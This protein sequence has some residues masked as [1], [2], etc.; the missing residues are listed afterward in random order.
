MTAI[1]GAPALR[2]RPR[3]A[4]T[5]ALAGA[6]G[7]LA[8]AWPL[9]IRHG[10]S[11]AH[12]ADAPWLF[13]L[14]LVLVLGVVL[15]EIAEGGMDAKAVALLGVLAAIG[16]ALRPLGAGA[17]GLETVWF[18]FV[19]AGRVLG[20]GF[21]FALGA[22]TLFASALL[23]A[24]VGPWLPFQMFGAAW[25]GFGAGCLPRSVRGRWEIAMLAGYGAL[26]ALAYGVLLDL[27]FWP[28][29]VAGSG[30]PSTL[31]YHPGAPVSDNLGRFVAFHLT[32]SMGFDLPRAGFTALLVALA[33]RPVLLA[34][35]R[36]ARRAAFGATAPR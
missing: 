29:T 31:A 33:A 10:S 13:V 2:L 24:G 4:L 34:L 8:F 9:L 26:A 16:A 25:V 14:L 18:L 3:T 20:R 17:A 11:V 21:G 23:T 5:L 32:T 19:L 27:S 30:A 15:A 1:S 22:L 36:A 28:F 7:T 6:V 35:R 12:A